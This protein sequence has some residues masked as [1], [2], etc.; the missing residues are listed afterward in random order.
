MYVNIYVT[1]YIRRRKATMSDAGQSAAKRCM[2]K[3]YVCVCDNVCMYVC[4]YVCTYVCMYVCMRI[5]TQKEGCYARH[6]SK[7]SKKVHAQNVCVYV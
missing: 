6:W 5:H 7:C 3:M 1:E 4:M 2:H